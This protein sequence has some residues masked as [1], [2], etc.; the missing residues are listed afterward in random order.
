LVEH[1]RQLH[2]PRDPYAEPCCGECCDCEL[3]VSLAEADEA[4]DILDAHLLACALCASGDDAC[5]TGQQL[6]AIEMGLGE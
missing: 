1:K 4:C 2:D 5:E 6:M 3:P